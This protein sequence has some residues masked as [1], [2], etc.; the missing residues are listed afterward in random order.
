MNLTLLNPGGFNA[1]PSRWLVVSP[2][3]TGKGFT[4]L[5]AGLTKR[6]LER[7]TSG[8]KGF[9][10]YLTRP[11]AGDQDVFLAA[12]AA[13]QHYHA[14]WVAPPMSP[15]SYTGLL[16]R[17]RRHS[18][19]SFL[20]KLRH[21]QQLAGLINFSNIIYGNL[22]SCF[23]GYYGFVNMAGHGYMTEGLRLAVYV[24]FEGLL[25]HR[26][27]ANIQPENFASKNLVRRVGFRREGFSRNYLLVA[28]EWRDHERWAILREEFKLR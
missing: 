21:D 16:R 7:M 8:I 24:A 1:W 20:I 26:I 15:A 19:D 3:Q 23:T 9:R 28:G 5:A 13:S 25:L 6:R 27:E 17:S 10:V 18:E 2:S 4:D 11:A 12:A 14:P 22:C